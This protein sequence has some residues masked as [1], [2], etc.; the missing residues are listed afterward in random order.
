MADEVATARDAL[1]QAAA[2]V[3]GPGT[4]NV[5]TVKTGPSRW[6]TWALVLAGP[7]ISAMLC[8]VVWVLV[9]KLW[10][11]IIGWESIE[12]ARRVV[13]ALGVIAVTLAAL[14]GVVVFRLAS[15]SL[16]SIK[17]V[18]GPGSLDIQSDDD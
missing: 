2:S 16:K 3:T 13:D 17:A 8:G 14:L 1:T 5:A 10:P 9:W 6:T 4:P 12:L 18:A 7:A 11:D 15:G